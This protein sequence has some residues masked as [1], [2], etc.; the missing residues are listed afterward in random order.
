MK[1]GR[2]GYFFPLLHKRCKVIHRNNGCITCRQQVVSKKS[3]LQ[4][5]PFNTNLPARFSKVVGEFEPDI[6]VLRRIFTTDIIPTD[7]WTDSQTDIKRTERQLNGC[8]DS[9]VNRC[10]DML[11]MLRSIRII[12]CHRLQKYALKRVYEAAFKMQNK[13]SPTDG[14]ADRQTQNIYT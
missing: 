14:Q 3:T 11:D 1:L 2:R 6:F 7:G 12:I 8:P 10:T 9:K 5:Y 13:C 4:A